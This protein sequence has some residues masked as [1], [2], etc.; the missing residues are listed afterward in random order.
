MAR[1]PLALLL[2]AV[3]GLAACGGGNDKQD[4][5][6]TV[7]EFVKATNDRDADKL[8]NDVFSKEFIAQ[9]TGASGD[10]AKSVCK[11]QFKQ[12]R[13]L[14]LKLVRIGKTTIDDDKAT[15]STVIETQDQPQPRLFRLTKED[16]DWR[17]AGGSGG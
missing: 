14:K 3:L 13:G 2:L 15:V 10:R 8:C 7:R 11:Q 16:G 5:E 9:A 4:A 1:R 17:L 6:Q 12:L